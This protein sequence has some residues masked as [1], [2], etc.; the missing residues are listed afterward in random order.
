MNSTIHPIL[1][2]HPIF[3]TILVIHII[4]GFTAL[5]SSFGALFSAKGQPRHRRFGKFFIS[6]MTGVFITAI[7]LA[8]MIQDLFLFLIAIFSYYLA[9]SGWRYAKNR[10]GIAN[11]TD[12]AVSIIMLLSSLIMIGFGLWIY[13]KTPNFHAYILLI[14][15]AIGFSSSLDDLRTYKKRA[16]VGKERIVKHLGAMLGASIAAITAFSV[17]NIPIHPAIILWITPTLVLSPVIFWWRR[18]ILKSP[19]G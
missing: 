7:P 3:F 9:F 15:G 18:R 16:A 4:L 2:D 5:I 19:D 11:K 6:G 1:P 13:Q 12:W 14:F 8:I 17:T 10:T